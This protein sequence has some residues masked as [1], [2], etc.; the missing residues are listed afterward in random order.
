MPVRSLSVTRGQ[1]SGRRRAF[2]R[3]S[4]IRA[5]G[6]QMLVNVMDRM[7]NMT[8]RYVATAVCPIGKNTDAECVA[9]EARIFDYEAAAA[10]AL[11]EHLVTAE[12]H[13]R[14]QLAK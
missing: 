2:L 1:A 5:R 6:A 14:E 9:L 7:V 10:A 13:T 8:H 11:L 12:C 4:E 3:H